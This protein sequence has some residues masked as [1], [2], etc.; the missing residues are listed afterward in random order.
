MGGLTWN[1]LRAYVELLHPAPIAVVLVAATGFC[2]AAVRGPL[3]RRR[4]ASFLGALVLTQCAIS[5]HNDYCDRELD[6]LTKPWR[7]LPRGLVSPGGALRC[8]VVLA[9][10]GFGLAAPLGRPVVVRLVLGT[11]A[12]F[13][14]NAWLK[15]SLWTWVP[16]AVALPTLPLGAFAA[17]G[18]RPP[19]PRLVYL[20][21]APLVLGVYLADSAADFESDARHGVRGLGQRLG[22]RKSLAGGW[23]ALGLAH[24]LALA[25]RPRQSRP[26]PLY[27]FAAVGLG[28]AVICGRLRLSGIRWLAAMASAVAVAIAWIAELADPG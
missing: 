3:P 21:G 26:G 6:R 19:R 5:L 17:M 20:V 15:R 24:F 1:R 14:Y 4:L 7:A 27:W 11:G 28:V 9:L 8:S 18:R 10:G 12:G 22:P 25:T 23:V 2:R 16:F 13:A